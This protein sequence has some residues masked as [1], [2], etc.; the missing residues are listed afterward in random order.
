M[1][2]YVGAINF[3]RGLVTTIYIVINWYINKY[4]RYAF[5]LSHHTFAS[6]I[7]LTHAQCSRGQRLK[8]FIAI[9]SLRL[10]EANSMQRRH[11]ILS[12]H[13]AHHVNNN[14][15]LFMF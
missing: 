7:D 10:S 3:H 9:W 5:F 12:I 8:A 2:M 4:T 11:R 14:F 15:C 6:T 1:M 13:L